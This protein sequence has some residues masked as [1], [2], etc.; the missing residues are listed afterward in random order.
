MRAYLNDKKILPDNSDRL[1]EE[2]VSFNVEMMKK[3]VFSFST[4]LLP[5]IIFSNYRFPMVSVGHFFGNLP[6]Q[7]GM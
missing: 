1:Y 4:A 7:I 5:F 6:T 3:T 2:V